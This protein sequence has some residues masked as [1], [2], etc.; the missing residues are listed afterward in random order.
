MNSTVSTIQLSTI[1]AASLSLFRNHFLNFIDFGVRGFNV[2]IHLIYFSYVALKKNSELHS[3]T[4]L[5]MHNVNISTMLIGIVCLSFTPFT[6][7]SFSNLTVNI[8]LCRLAELFWMWIKYGR[9]FSL[10]YLSIYRYIGCFKIRLYNQINSSL[11]NLFGLIMSCWFFSFVIPMS[12]KIGLGTTFSVL[13]CTDG[14]APDNLT[15]SIVY[16][17][18]NTI[19]SSFIPTAAIFVIYFKIYQKLK[20][21]SLKIGGQKT[22][23]QKV[24]K[25]AKQFI[26]INFITSLSTVLATFVDFVNVIAVR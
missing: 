2:I 13:W 9:T 16:Y 12:F 3:R 22:Q 23:L 20:E 18:V 19:L 10:L 26:I 15:H 24:G 17:I 5:F 14:F 7:P 25:Y 1:Q 21:Q 8:V 4:C 6:A 11:F